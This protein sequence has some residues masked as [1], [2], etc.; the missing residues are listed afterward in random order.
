MA[1]KNEYH[2]VING[3]QQGPFDGSRIEAMITSGE[4]NGKTDVWCEEMDDWEEAALVP[5]LAGFFAKASKE[6]PPAV[7]PLK[8]APQPKAEP[9]VISP[10]EP[11]TKVKV[12]KEA[13]EQAKK[14]A[15]AAHAFFVKHDYKSA[16]AEYTKATELNPN[17]HDHF[18]YLG[19]NLEN[20]GELEKAL[21]AYNESIRRN[22]K[23]TSP[24]SCRARIWCKLGNYD[25]AAENLFEALKIEPNFSSL[26]YELGEVCMAMKKYS[27][28][29]K[30]FE[31]AANL[32]AKS[33]KK[34]IME[35]LAEAKR[36]A[37]M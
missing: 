3:E 2:V 22:P 9:A 21:A 34:A 16:V 11:F 20:A 5:E 24:Y 32:A 18:F 27:F 30:V 26:N 19:I 12:S 14:H 15:D 17:S 1:I 4:L 25:N 13:I 29:C 35:K 37:E 7:E 28:A 23:D 31:K 33:D 6:E 8:P 36:L 10:V